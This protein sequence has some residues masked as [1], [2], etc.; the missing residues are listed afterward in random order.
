[1]N[2]SGRTA[3]HPWFA[4]THSLSPPTCVRLRTLNVHS[5][6]DLW[7]HGCGQR[8]SYSGHGSNCSLWRLRS[9][10]LAARAGAPGCRGT[11]RPRSGGT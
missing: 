11:T 1:M 7:L 5:P 2:Q 9:V 3:F 10:S 4:T 6:H 8:R